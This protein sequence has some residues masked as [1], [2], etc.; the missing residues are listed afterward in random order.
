VVTNI[1]V[2]L[3][4]ARSA[5]P[6]AAIC[7]AKHRSAGHCGAKEHRRSVFCPAAP[8][9]AISTNAAEF[10]LRSTQLSAQ[11]DI[12][13]GLGVW[14]LPGL[15]RSHNHE[16]LYVFGLALLLCREQAAEAVIHV[17][18]NL[19][20]AAEVD[21]FANWEPEVRAVRTEADAVLARTQ[22]WLSRFIQVPEAVVEAATRDALVTATR[23]D[24]KLCEHFQ[25]V[26]MTRP[27]VAETYAEW[28]APLCQGAEL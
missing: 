15:W 13:P 10:A 6:V 7:G 24:T 9:L 23:A 28:A 25:T 1:A 17:N 11:S 21:I 4:F 18:T 3:Q 14:V 8:V 27:V 26:R 2:F 19:P 12:W 16:T 20:A 22:S 5:V